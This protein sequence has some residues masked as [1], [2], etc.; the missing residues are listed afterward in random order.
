MFVRTFVSNKLIYSP[1]IYLKDFIYIQKEE[2]WGVKNTP[3]GEGAVDFKKYFQLLND[4][5]I[6]API[7]LHAEYEL[8]GANH[9]ARK[10]TI[11]AEK[12]IAAL[13]QDLNRLRI[14]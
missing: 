10:L 2:E 11:P 3:I 5:S 12:V 6:D 14:V 13:K 9:G 7:S 1:R 4:L 8:G